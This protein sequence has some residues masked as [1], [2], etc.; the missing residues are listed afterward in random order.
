VDALACGGILLLFPRIWRAFLDHRWMWLLALAAGGT[1]VGFSWGVVVGDVV[2]V[3][4]LTY[5]M[6]AWVVLLAWPLLGEKP[7]RG[8]LARLALALGGMV[9]VLKTP[10]SPWPVPESFAD[11]LGLLGGL[12]FAMVNIMLRKLRAAP[13]V[14]NALA[15]FGGG[16]LGCLLAAL[17]GMQFGMVQAMPPLEV[18]WV[19]GVLLLT[20]AIIIANSTLQYGAARLPANTTSIIM[21]LEVVFASVSSI[22]LGAGVLT[23]NTLI[24]GALIFAACIWSA[25][26]SAPPPAQP[27]ASP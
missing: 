15:M 4:L 8:A 12:S 26:S 5:L 14:A 11:A 18:E 21:L 6:P 20:V 16:G 7:D 10:D 2:R 3:T 13:P 24:G 19:V 17:A 22:W 27:A 1:N 25:M 23:Q 9:V